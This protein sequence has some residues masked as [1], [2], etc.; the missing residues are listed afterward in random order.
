MGSG[1]STSRPS[2]AENDNGT[3]HHRKTPS[4]G[5]SLLLRKKRLSSFHELST[6]SE[7]S[8]LKCS[9][10]SPPLS[11]RGSQRW[12]QNTPFDK[13][14]VLMPATQAMDP[15]TE[16]VLAIIMTADCIPD[17]KSEEK[18][19]R[20][21][22]CYP[23]LEE[24]MR[25]ASVGM[26]TA[27]V[28]SRRSGPSAT[29]SATSSSATTSTTTTTMAMGPTAPVSTALPPSPLLLLLVYTREGQCCLLLQCVEEAKKL[30]LRAISLAEQEIAQRGRMP[31]EE[32][33][34]VVVLLARYVQAMIGLSHVWY[35]EERAKG[36]FYS[37]Q[38]ALQHQR[39]PQWSPDACVRHR[40]GSGRVRGSVDDAAASSSSS[41]S[42]ILS[43]LPRG[44]KDE[45][46]RMMGGAGR[47]CGISPAAFADKQ[48]QTA[49]LSSLMGSTGS[50]FYASSNNT[51][52]SVFSL[53]FHLIQSL[54]PRPPRRV[55]GPKLQSVNIPPPHI[56]EDTEYLHALEEEFVLYSKM[57]RELLASPAELL[58]LRCCEVVE[59]VHSRHS[60]LLL[61]VLETLAN[62]YEELELFD[63]AILLLRRAVGILLS[64]YDYDYPLVLRILQRLDVLAEKR[65]MQR[66]V[67]AAIRIQS[68][69]R[70]FQCMHQLSNVLQRPVHR[71]VWM[72][73]TDQPSHDEGFLDNFWFSQDEEEDTEGEGRSDGKDTETE[74]L[75]KLSRHSP[76]SQRAPPPLAAA[77]AVPAPSSFY[78]SSSFSSSFTTTSSSS[79]PPSSSTPASISLQPLSSVQL[80][81]STSAVSRRHSGYHSHSHHSKKR[82]SHHASHKHTSDTTTT[83]NNPNNTVY[84]PHTKVIGTSQETLTTTRLD[85]SPSSFPVD[86]KTNER[87]SNHDDDDETG[88]GHV[89]TVETTTITKLVSEE[90]EKKATYK[91]RKEKENSGVGGEAM[92]RELRR[93]VS[94]GG[95]EEPP[96]EQ[97]SS[98][99]SSSIQG[100]VW[101][102]NTSKRKGK[103]K[104][105][106]EEEEEEIR[107]RQRDAHNTGKKQK[108]S[109]KSIKTTHIIPV[110]NTIMKGNVED[111]D[112]EG[113]NTTVEATVTPTADGEVV[114]IRQVTV[115]RTIT[116]EVEEEEE[117]EEEEEIRGYRFQQ[118]QAASYRE[119]KTF[120]SPHHPS[121]IT[122][123]TSTTTTST[124]TT[125]TTSSPPAGGGGAGF[126]VISSRAYSQ[127]G[128][129]SSIPPSRL[130]VRR[131]SYASSSSSPTPTPTTTTGTTT[132]S[133]S[134]SRLSSSR[135]AAA[136]ALAHASTVMRAAA[137]TSLS[138]R[139]EEDGKIRRQ[140]KGKEG[141]QENYHHGSRNAEERGHCSAVG[142]TTAV[143]VP[144]PLLSSSV[145][146]SSSKAG[147][148]GGIVQQEHQHPQYF[149]S[150]SGE[151]VTYQN[152]QL[153]SLTQSNTAGT[154]DATKANT[155][156]VM[157]ATNSYGSSITRHHHHYHRS[158]SVTK[159]VL[160]VQKTSS[161]TGGGVAL[162]G[163]EGNTSPPISDGNQLGHLNYTPSS[164]LVDVNGQPS[165]SFSSSSSSSSSSFSPSAV[166]AGAT[167]ESSGL[168]EQ[169]RPTPQSHSP[170]TSSTPTTTTRTTTTH[171]SSTPH[172]LPSLPSR[173]GSSGVAS[174]LHTQESIYHLQQHLQQEQRRR[175]NSRSA[176]EQGGRGRT[177][178]GE[179]EEEK[180]REEN[181]T[182]AKFPSSE[183]GGAGG[184]SMRM[185]PF[186]A[187]SSSPRKMH[188][189]R[190]AGESSLPTSGR[191]RW[192]SSG[193]SSGAGG[194]GGSNSGR[195]SWSGAGWSARG[196][197]TGEL[198]L[199][200]V[201]SM[202][203]QSQV[204]SI[205]SSGRRQRAAWS[206]GRG[207]EDAPHLRHVTPR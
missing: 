165:G 38:A 147:Y 170:L 3:A 205:L 162:P 29:F 156:A 135:L 12:I 52:S 153:A 154:S 31:E 118:Q 163:L 49:I 131:P 152:D 189:G 78:G 25:R 24:A 164:R 151:K 129:P 106:R 50:V 149:V 27:D 192:S 194:G 160:G 88:G 136:N 89:L 40:R 171:S 196:G 203:S 90:D 87:K 53:N 5:F 186:S 109:H 180:G 126:P 26:R 173:D 92:V 60:P 57:P 116:E 1:A 174:S 72:S 120:T 199:I 20:I 18:R 80:S 184:A 85:E 82:T 43:S 23:I 145:P 158:G 123:P 81:S 183:T 102:K 75:P 193:R 110:R 206:A 159:E 185:T 35:A 133:S 197:S 61:P 127:P 69:W 74:A 96:Q 4:R 2:P 36:F 204:S 44:D 150:K 202:D 32:I 112:E 83:N 117:D 93:E 142:P 111:G 17:S 64:V 84:M 182:Q 46:R 140:E 144:F 198:G 100:E 125:T 95:E 99:S 97:S 128:G 15:V 175:R 161:R 148:A 67:R 167:S 101:A 103:E 181:T 68:I 177:R 176:G 6:G 169:S 48:H 63:S 73:D 13:E 51:S 122:A 134:S 113:G 16:A 8:S 10:V 168:S 34:V 132:S 105:E 55:T 157:V 65:T 188:S 9:S 59:V 190:G 94:T 41:S 108:E 56:S 141:M 104:D 121:N 19:K 54:L 79:P 191:D 39:E 86:R 124:S 91:K 22:Q 200:G 138:R 11:I 146:S 115:T 71:H 62:L 58:L 37:Q 130:P 14:D 28:G 179:E 201:V 139:E 30:F 45:K 98:S 178:R 114:T 21:Q 33:P 107:Q 7:I 172:S 66:K 77:G 195:D 47:G 137:A 119:H 143:T 155:A 70:M 42:S 207:E 76:T 166:R 187:A